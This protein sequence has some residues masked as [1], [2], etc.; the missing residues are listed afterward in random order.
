MQRGKRQKK[1]N[2]RRVR[3]QNPFVSEVPPYALKERQIV[4]VEEALSPTSTSVAPI[5]ITKKM[6]INTAAQMKTIRTFR[7]STEQSVGGAT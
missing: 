2:N 4:A 1:E 5:N 3:E 7:D 6:S